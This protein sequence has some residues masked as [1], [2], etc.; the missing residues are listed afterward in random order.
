MAG[1]S[2]RALP[3]SKSTQADTRPVR[4]VVAHASTA[5]STITRLAKIYQQV[6]SF[7]QSKAYNVHS[8]SVEHVHLRQSVAALMLANAGY[9]GL[10]F[11]SGVGLKVISSK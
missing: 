8:L 2:H 7:K 9:I 5:H 10:Y 6:I 11:F 3:H 1:Q 4:N